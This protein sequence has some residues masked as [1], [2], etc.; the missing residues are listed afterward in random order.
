MSV[1][2]YLR[3]MRGTTR[4]SPPRVSNRE[5]FWSW[6]GGFAGIAAVAWVHRLFFE[7]SDLT[8]MIGS[9]GASAVLVYGAV[10]SPLAQPRNLVGGHVISALVGVVAWK[11][12]HSE[13]WLAQAVA[14]ATAIAL[15][16]ATRTLH[17]PGGATALIAV[18]GSP[19][20]H[21]MGFVY[22]LVPATL[23][24]LIL[25]AVAL[26]VNNLPASRRYPEVWF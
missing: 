14:V 2:E 3:K 24:P 4:G 8:L 17:P 23:G 13:P 19:R 22:V 21:E 25:L 5:I 18:I 11:L 1:R 9:F 6:I 16:H 15:M 12:L 26:V 7:Q 10:R 20:I